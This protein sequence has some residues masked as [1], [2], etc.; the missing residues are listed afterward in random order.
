MPH[1]SNTALAR[2]QQ[3]MAAL[4]IA[5]R[6]EVAAD[7]QRPLKPTTPA[8]IKG[9]QVAIARGHLETAARIERQ[10]LGGESKKE[11]A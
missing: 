10:W 5:M 9:K 1:T 4:G 6:R 11:A 7:L 8:W 2:A 3:A